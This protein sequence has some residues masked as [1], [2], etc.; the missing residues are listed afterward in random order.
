[1]KFNDRNVYISKSANI[2]SNVRIGDNTSIYDN[3]SIGDNTVIGSDCIIGEPVNAYYNDPDSYQN[4]STVI[5]TNSMIRSKCII[6]AGTSFGENLI[7]GHH[8]TV[9]EGA[10]FG[11]N[12]LIS[13]LADVQN[14]CSIGDYS[15]LYSN[16]HVGEHTKLGNYVFVFPFT[17]F[18]NDP[19]PPSE[20]LLGSTVGDYS[21]ITVHCSV[22]PG[23]NIGTHCLIGANSVISRNIDDYSFAIGSPAKRLKDIR[24]LPSKEKEGFHYPWPENFSRGMPWQGMDYNEWLSAIS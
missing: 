17:V 3:V 21:I 24:E 22:M 20:T 16:V 1:M 4:A 6:Y 10:V 13:T 12:C 2:G 23:I 15:R 5:G 7:T 19:L 8:V 14:N 11:K 18:T 9:R